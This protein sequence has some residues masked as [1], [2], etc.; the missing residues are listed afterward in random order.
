MGMADGII[1]TMSLSSYMDEEDE[2]EEDEDEEM[3]PLSTP[4][5]SLSQATFDGSVHSLWTME[6]DPN[7][8]LFGGGGGKREICVLPKRN[9]N[10]NL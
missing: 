5:S 7:R 3:C 6:G 2:E 8:V 10:L 4:T 1:D 9:Q